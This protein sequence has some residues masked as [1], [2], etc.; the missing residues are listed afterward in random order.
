MGKEFGKEKK[1]VCITESLYC[2]RETNSIVKSTML[3]YKIKKFLKNSWMKNMK[4]Y[5]KSISCP[6]PKKTNLE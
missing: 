4:V 1:H 5:W 2:T 3:Q 6:P